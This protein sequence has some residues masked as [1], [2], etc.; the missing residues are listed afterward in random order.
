MTGEDKKAWIAEE[1]SEALLADG[2]EDALVGVGSQFGKPPV[3]VYDKS[4]CRRVLTERD[5]MTPDEAQEYLEFNV[6]GAYMGEGTPIFIDLFAHM[7]EGG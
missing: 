7:D 6:Y 5:G 3:A 1:N 2:F 4:L